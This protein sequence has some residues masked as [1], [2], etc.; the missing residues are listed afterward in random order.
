MS[1]EINIE[2]N[3]TYRLWWPSNENE[4]VYKRMLN[5]VTDVDKAVK[6]CKSHGVAVQAG[7]FI[8]MWPARLARWFVEVY[9]FEPIPHL[10]ECAKKNTSH[11]P[12]VRVHN[13]GL[14]SRTGQMLIAQKRGGCSKMYTDDTAAEKPLTVP[15]ATIDSLGL[16]RCDL[17]M[18]DVETHELEALQGAAETIGT[19]RPVVV[20][21]T[22][23]ETRRE[24]DEFMRRWKYEPSEKTHAD[25]VYTP[26]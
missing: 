18:L 11:L 4:N 8:G 7:G 6:Y 5:R 2:W 22:G 16:I 23:E 1:E 17:I 15:V 24:Y 13:S 21:E 3:D 9:T 20:L 19:F 10:Y 12:N 14:S 26:R 25:V